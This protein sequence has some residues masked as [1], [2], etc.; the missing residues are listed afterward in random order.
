LGL[1]PSETARGILS[2]GQITGGIVFTGKVVSDVVQ[3]D[4]LDTGNVI[5][6]ATAGLILLSP[7]ALGKALY[8]PTGIRWLTRG[9][10]TP[11]GSREAGQIISR[12]MA[13]VNTPNVGRRPMTEAEFNEFHGI[14]PTPQRPLRSIGNPSAP[15]ITFSR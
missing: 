6:N 1:N 13:V 7:V 11:P 15:Q 5:A 9:L 14:T 4:F 3:G 12:I 2:A 10:Q 8:T